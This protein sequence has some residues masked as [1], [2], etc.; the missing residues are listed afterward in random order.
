MIRK[1]GERMRKMIVVLFVIVG[2]I[3]GAVN[4]IGEFSEEGSL[5]RADF[6][7]DITDE[8]GAN[9]IPCGGEGGGGGGGLP[10]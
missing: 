5:I 10:G 3:L 9:P 8:G 7:R 2:M 4:V 1:R 6:P